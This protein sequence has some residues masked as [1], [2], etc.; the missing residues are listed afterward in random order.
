MELGVK[1]W[2]RNTDRGTV[3]GTIQGTAV[4]IKPMKY[5]LKNKGSRSSRIDNCVFKEAQKSESFAAFEIRNV[6]TVLYVDG[7]L[8]VPLVFSFQGTARQG[9]LSDTKNYSQTTT[10]TN[11]DPHEA[12]ISASS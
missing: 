4:N 2:V 1:G 11:D 8:L 10:E 12:I 6:W 9:P 7:P 5:W 3:E